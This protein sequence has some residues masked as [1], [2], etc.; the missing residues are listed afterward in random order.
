MK[1]PTGKL[2]V[3]SVGPLDAEIAVIAESPAS[4][5][6]ELGQ[7]LV[8]MAGKTFDMG[9]AKAGIARPSIRIINL[10]PVR[11]PHDKFIE[12]DSRDLEWGHEQLLRE[13]DG[14]PNLK[15]IVPMG[16]HPLN[17]LTGG[18]FPLLGHDE[19][20]GGIRPYKNLHGDTH[21]GIQDWRGSVMRYG[22]EIL[23]LYPHYKP[24]TS[25]T[26]V[27]TFHPAYVGRFFEAHID[28]I[29]DLKR[30]KQYAEGRL[31]PRPTRTSYVDN[32]EAFDRLVHQRRKDLQTDTDPEGFGNLGERPVVDLIAFDTEQRFRDVGADLVSIAT[33]D[34]VHVIHPQGAFLPLLKELLENHWVAKVAHNYQHDAVWLR[35]RFGIHLTTPRF[36]TYGGAHVLNPSLEKSLSPGISNRFVSYGFFHKWLEEVDQSRY[37]GYDAIVT[38]DAYWP[39]QEEISR[40]GLQPVVSHDHKLMDIFIEMTMRGFKVDTTRRD[41]VEAELAAQTKEAD[42]LLN[43]HARPL[44][45]AK[46]SKFQKPHLFRED[47]TPKCSC[48][49]GGTRQRKHCWKCAVPFAGAFLVAAD[50]ILDEKGGLKAAAKAAGYKSI[51]AFVESWPECRTC[52]GTGKTATSTWLSF[53]ADSPDQVSDLIYRGLGIHPRTYKG[54][55]TVRI[56]QLEP[57]RDL[58]PLVAEV[59][60]AQKLRA[61]METVMRLKPGLDG[62]LHCVFDPWGTRHGRV[63]GKEG[64]ILPGTNPMN[65][66]YAARVFVVPDEG[67]FLLYPDME[68]IEARNMAVLSG[69][70]GIRQALT[71]V[72]PEK[73]K[74]DI[75]LAVVK[76]LH[77]QAKFDLS[78]RQAKKLE[79][80]AFYGIR[81]SNLSKEMG[82]DLQTAERA[83]KAFYYVFD[84]VPVWHR[85]VLEEA[86]DTR[87]L[88]SPTGRICTWQGHIYDAKTKTVQYETAKEMWSFKPQDM[89]AWVLALGLY[90]LAEVEWLDLLIHVHDACVMQAELTRRDEAITV[91][92]NALTR[93]V[94]NMLY[95]A[96]MKFGPNWKEVA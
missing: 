94:W 11:A 74:S 78:R 76:F 44:V 77:A 59:I 46:L 72:Q 20:T 6:V 47:K 81:A 60:D 19:N 51:K 17:W 5:E 50:E 63:A 37:S 41:E 89:A 91:A 95:P 43:E 79:Y 54:K 10:V 38:Y 1:S 49:G 39:M 65:I 56:K 13:L 53:S 66:P 90:D 7:P 92:Q 87:E 71:E 73:G 30:A 80:A 32:L 68:Q 34:E 23:G 82:T 48:C 52:H 25:T 45:E 28:F 22:D 29:R 3:P 57:I 61:D 86:L 88:K 96:E 15:V 42:R 93:V 12:H 70:D 4:R 16:F 2:V 55:E 35:H 40:R 58:H 31:P 75:H 83:L 14:L 24:I 33:E 69:D 36:D 8:G 26:L 85:A 18:K 84:K 21:G 27:P 67:K 9:L 64:L 62:R